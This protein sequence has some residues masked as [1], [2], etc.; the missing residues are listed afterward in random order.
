MK[1]RNLNGVIIR[2]ITVRFIFSLESQGEK[3]GSIQKRKK[4][5]KEVFN[6]P[7]AVTAVTEYSKLKGRFNPDAVRP[8]FESDITI[9]KVKKE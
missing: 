4:K 3:K 2:L 8:L 9:K 5:T 1:N 6:A 7:D